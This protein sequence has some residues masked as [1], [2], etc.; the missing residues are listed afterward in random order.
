MAND[1]TAQ[2][3]QNIKQLF[4]AALE[5]EPRARAA[6]LTEACGGDDDLRREVESLLAAHAQTDSF[7]DR[8]AFEAAA[9]LL[10]TAE[11]AVAAGGTIGPYQVVEQIGRG[12]MGE[13]YLARDTRLGRRVALKLLPPRFTSDEDRLRRFKQEA[14]AAS[15]LNHPNIITIHE[16]G[17]VDGAHF[18]AT[19]F[20]EGRTLR[21]A[22]EAGALPL[23]QTLD[24]AIQVAGALAAAHSAGIVHRDIKPENIM[25]RPDGYV[26][27]LDFGIAKLTSREA[28]DMRSSGASLQTEPGMIIGTVNYMSPEQARG[29]RVD[30]RSD[31]FSLAAVVYE[32]A[33]GRVPFQGDSVADVIASILTVEPR[34]LSQYSADNPPELQRIIDKALAKEKEA[35][36]QS[37]GHMLDELKQLKR[38][39]DFEDELERSGP[40]LGAASAPRLTV[41]PE[42]P[43]T[44]AITVEHVSRR[45]K[46]VT[47]AAAAA[48]ALAVVAGFVAYRLVAARRAAQPFQAMRII[49]L[50]TTGKVSMAA[51]SPG[52]K[53]VAHAVNH[54][55]QQG[56]W[57]RHVATLSNVQIVPPADCEYLG[58]TFSNDSNYIYY[59]MWDKKNPAAL[60]QV[61]VLGSAPRKLVE[62][63]DSSVTFSPDGT[64][65]AFVRN[66]DKALV[67]ANT[68]DLAEHNLATRA[69]DE[70]WR[71][72]AWSPD[73][74]TIA[75]GVGGITSGSEYAVAVSVKDGSERVITPQKWYRVLWLAWL[76]DGGSLV[77]SAADPESKINQVWGLSLADGEA[78]R[79]TN[80]LSSYLGV[81]LTADSSA[82]LC[83][84]GERLA[85]IWA[86]AGGD[87]GRARQVTFGESTDEGLSGISWTPDGRIVYGSGARGNQDIWIVN[88]DGS[89]QRQLTAN[90][91]ADLWPEV[92]PDGRYI[93]FVS[94]R[95]GGSNIW[96]MDIDGGN[97]KRLTAGSGES[98][99][100]CSPDGRWAVYQISD[101]RETTIWR[102]P[103]EGGEP[104]Q[105]T[106]KD[107]RRPV[108]SPDGK[109]IACHFVDESEGGASK[110]A[111]IPFEGG[112][113]IKLFN[114]PAAIRSGLLKW[115]ADGRALSYVDSRGGVS[116]IWAWPIDGGR[117]SQVT[118]FK[119]GRI[120]YFDWSP[121]G[122]QLAYSHGAE[123][124]DI[125][126]ISNF[127]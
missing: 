61:A 110:V 13:V 25:L 18:I 17:Q 88:A 6:F 95:A 23:G 75:C 37:T 98:R 59:A 57:L 99:P 104:V 82:L 14:R 65:F 12:G 125:V 97:A 124:Y 19:E 100:H 47:S 74:E 84:Q 5:R 33:A 51:I 73:G 22:I 79:I 35:R 32:M 85:N 9:G 105:V 114:I 44:A 78:R 36:Y 45:K 123:T 63:I 83:V 11:H 43:S 69:G 87:A 71:Y 53:Y 86:A 91:N 115:T 29:Q 89:D 31:I 126:L 106:A 70:F 49:R 21:Q 42:H 122:R 116:N 15:A 1:L 27:V 50:T 77:M 41:P 80:D 52:G 20:I 7:I 16:V 72:P 67:V 94:D 111:V 10:A 93:V 90:A 46:R 120:F 108:V 113:P 40:S 107:S 76:A 118:D 117:P 38:R 66:E 112:P 64:R 60:Y 48:A 34:P 68:A 121:D 26:K 101:G 109:L 54:A 28:A 56:L 39:L 81:S 102:V 96:R 62:R 3:W 103:I 119:E 24:V 30:A 127:R 55:G 92:T 58:L 2:R 4:H 8:P